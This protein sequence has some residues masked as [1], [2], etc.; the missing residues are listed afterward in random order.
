MQKFLLDLSRQIGAVKLGDDATGPKEEV[1]PGERVIGTLP[2]D[3]RKL[4]V[5]HS[6]HIDAMNGLCKGFHASSLEFLLGKPPEP[7]DAVA[8]DQH[9]VLHRQVELVSNIFW[10]SVR[11]AFPGI[12][13]EDHIGIRK[14][15]Q[16]VVIREPELPSSAVGLA[17]LLSLLGR[18]PHRG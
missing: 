2:E 1:G 10:H 8:A 3:V 13:C 12:A 15:W 16:V 14:D 18:Q 7:E 6:N 9:V 5:V 17:T 11:R 4:F